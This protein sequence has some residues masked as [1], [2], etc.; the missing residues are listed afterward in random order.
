MFKKTQ[1]VQ[2]DTCEPIQFVFILTFEFVKSALL[3]WWIEQNQNQESCLLLVASSHRGFPTAQVCRSCAAGCASCGKNATH[4]LSCEEPLLL[5]KH[6]CVQECPPAHMA[7]DWEC[8]RCPSSCRECSPLGRCTGAGE[9]TRAE[10]RLECSGCH[11]FSTVA[12]VHLVDNH[13]LLCFLLYFVLFHGS[14]HVFQTICPP[15]FTDFSPARFP[16]Q[17]F[18]KPKQY[19]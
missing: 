1:A 18:A 7:R 9:Q 17:I 6:Q 2:L 13:N 19:S 5:H 10:S 16:L 4:C 15:D 12:S 3:I 8:H 14:N 11:F